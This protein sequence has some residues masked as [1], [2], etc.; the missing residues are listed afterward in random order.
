[1]FFSAVDLELKA[2]GRAS[3]NYPSRL[4]SINVELAEE[5]QQS[6]PSA[7][8]NTMNFNYVSDVC[9]HGR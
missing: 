7:N 9:V 1:M 4:V 3:R 6:T 2:T 5:S 8:S